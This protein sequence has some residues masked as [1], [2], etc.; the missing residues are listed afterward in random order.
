[1]RG[2]F[3]CG[4]HVALVCALREGCSS[5]G[6]HPRTRGEGVRA[7]ASSAAH[8]SG[9]AAQANFLRDLNR[10][11]DHEAVVRAFESGQLASSEAMLSEYV[12]ALVAVDRLDTSSLIRTL[13]VR[14]QGRCCCTG[15]CRSK[16]RAEQSPR[17]FVFQEAAFW[18]VSSARAWLHA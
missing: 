4:D 12:K 13:Q 7:F 3:C 2:G 11:G 6:C 15:G 16:F 5:G 10:R 8:D 17:A 18:A 9:V 1:M 14:A